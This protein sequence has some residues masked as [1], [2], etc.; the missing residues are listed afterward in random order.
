MFPSLRVCPWIWSQSSNYSKSAEEILGINKPKK[1]LNAYVRFTK[2]MRPMLVEKNPS[3][4]VVTITKLAAKLW[5][6]LDYEVYQTLVQKNKTLNQTSFRLGKEQAVQRLRKG[7]DAVQKDHGGV[8]SIALHQRQSE[9]SR[10]RT[11]ATCG[12]REEKNE[13]SK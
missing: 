3:A 5:E 1:P 4:N 13:K 7:N 9:H 8:Q 6:Q 12:E 2:Q 10:V 11:K